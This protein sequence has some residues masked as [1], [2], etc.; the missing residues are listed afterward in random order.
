GSGNSLLKGPIDP[1]SDR[2]S[3]AEGGYKRLLPF[4]KDIPSGLICGTRRVV[5]SN[6]NESWEYARAL[7]GRIVGEVRIVS[8][9]HFS[10][11]TSCAS[12]RNDLAYRKPRRMDCKLF[13]R[14]K[15]Y[16]TRSISGRKPSIGE[17]YAIKTFRVLGS[18]SK[19]YQ[20]SPIL[21]HKSDVL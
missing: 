20:R 2:I 14:S 8:R 19:P 3:V 5:G 17:R 15:C 6:G 7:F 10:T 16:R 1:P 11:E 13:P 4:E 12:G 9:N 18:Q 21:T